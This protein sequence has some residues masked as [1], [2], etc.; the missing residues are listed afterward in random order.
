MILQLLD[1]LAS[2]A[3]RKFKEGVL[4]Q[5]KHNP[6]LKE[7]FRLALDPSINFYIKKIPPYTPRVDGGVRDLT[8]AITELD[9]LATRDVTGND[10]IEFLG[11]VLEQLNQDDAEVLKRVVQRDLRCGVSEATVNKIWKGLIPEYPYLRCCLPKQAKLDKFD[12][13]RGVF[14]QM[15]ADGAF[16][17]IN[18]Y[19]DGSV[20]LLTRSGSRVPLDQLDGLV[21]DIV[22]IFPPG[23]QTHGEMLVEV[24]GEIQPREI[25]NG[26]INRVLKGGKFDLED[27]LVLVV[28]DQ[29][30]LAE[31]R[32][33]NK[34]RVDYATRYARLKS[35]V[36]D[37]VTVSIYM[38]DTKIVHSMEDALEHY[39]EM[40]AGGYEG[41]IIK[42]PSAIWEDTTSKKQVKLKLETTVDLKIVGFTAGKGKNADTFGS[43]VCESSDGLLQ[44]N[45]SGFKDKKQKGVLTRAEVWELRD[46]LIDTVMAVTS[47]N[48]MAPAKSNNKYSLFLPRCSE[49]RQDKTEADNLQQI[50]DQFDSVIR[51][52]GK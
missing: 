28:W 50:I 4:E 37:A 33:G 12:W 31:A 6:L 24:G 32:P 16:V 15:K 5:N 17:S 42:D 46:Q 23:T 35:H 13:K 30:P 48:I 8:W 44:V 20:E 51:G 36:A 22:T 43:V 29:I 38:V 11:T 1:Q 49:L 45:V 10:A 27:H 14:S 3:G 40:L 41:T 52:S 47:N 2:D 9:H 25:G 7:V 18:H 19:N 39:S 26:I 21:S 34:Y